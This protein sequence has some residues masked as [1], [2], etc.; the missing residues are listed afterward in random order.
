MCPGDDGRRQPAQGNGATTALPAL[1]V[2]KSLLHS[3]T[4]LIALTR[5]RSAHTI[6]PI[7]PITMISFR[8]IES[9]GIVLFI[10]FGVAFELW[11]KLRK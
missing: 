8:L 9:I 1:D 4:P 5:C 3:L 7:W 6:H 11:L 10:L 2:Q